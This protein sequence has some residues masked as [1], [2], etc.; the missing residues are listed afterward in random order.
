MDDESLYLINFV[1]ERLA[2]DEERLDR[3]PHLADGQLACKLCGAD[4]YSGMAGDR[5][6]D[7]AT[8]MEFVHQKTK[9]LADVAAKRR[10]AGIARRMVNAGPSEVRGTGGAILLSLASPYEDHKGFR[11]QWRTDGL[12]AV[13]QYGPTADY[14][15]N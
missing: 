12:P 10:V 9:A 2:E 1:L 4:L 6:D 8:H 14:G 5:A 11:E 13:G 15:E 3:P 7:W